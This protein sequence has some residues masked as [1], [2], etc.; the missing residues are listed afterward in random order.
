MSDQP[1]RRS[2]YDPPD[3][4][5][6]CVNDGRAL[7]ADFRSYHA[8]LAE[9]H[10]RALHG[11][12]I[13]D[14]LEV[15]G[16]IGGFVLS[17]RPGAAIDAQGRTIVLPAQGTAGLASG[18]ATPEFQSY[19]DNLSI[20]TTGLAGSFALTI[21]FH[22]ELV[23][24]GLD[25]APC[26][27]WEQRPIVRIRPPGEVPGDEVPLAVFDVDDVGKLASIAAGGR[28]ATEMELG[29][30]RFVADKGH[31]FFTEPALSPAATT[32][33]DVTGTMRANPDE[34]GLKVDAPMLVV[35]GSLKMGGSILIPDSARRRQ[36]RV[37]LSSVRPISPDPETGWNVFFGALQAPL[38]KFSDSIVPIL[39][40]PQGGRIVSLSITCGIFPGPAAVKV[41]VGLTVM[42]DRLSTL[43]DE[44]FH[45]LLTVAGPTAT[46]DLQVSPQIEI[47]HENLYQISL[48]KIAQ[49]TANQF[50]GIV[51]LF[52]GIEVP[53]LY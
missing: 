7:D 13:A 11:S 44:P 18:N 31:F 50:V 28:T 46:T 26:K 6:N 20:P 23:N 25:V 3:S 4:G 45:T 43:S 24:D 41:S 10:N 12:G 40:L 32:R 30:L 16:A 38:N 33:R 52:V 19:H 42:S 51:S 22:E 34:P 9:L 47:N 8:P 36:I 53:S 49:A 27:S 5:F 2:N 14:G 1:I 37:D 29:E 48:Q 17:L 15:G 39:N 21:A 35:T